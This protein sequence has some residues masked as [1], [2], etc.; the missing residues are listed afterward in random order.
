MSERKDGIIKTEC[1]EFEDLNAIP[2]VNEYLLMKCS[3]RKVSCSS[4][5]LAEA[6]VPN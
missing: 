6:L 3:V 4:N 2:I 5:L 1:Q